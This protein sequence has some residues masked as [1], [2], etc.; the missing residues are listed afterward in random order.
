MDQ[1]PAF[2]SEHDSPADLPPPAAT[3]PESANGPGSESPWYREGL[4][5]RCTQCGNC[6][7]GS[8][9]AVWVNDAE[10]QQIAEYLDKPIGEI[11]LF[12]TRP[13][14]GQVSLREYAN[15]DCIFFDGLTR[16]CQIY[17][18]RPRQCRTWPFWG[19]NLTDEAAWQTTCQICPGSG[20]GDLIPLQEIESRRHE[21]GL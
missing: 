13:L 17:P 14:R 15:G 21:S 5:F 2:D 7:T 12:H 8:S 6:C 11:R 4:K 18:V 10:I 16:R 9:G 19:S 20:Q 3:N 1:H